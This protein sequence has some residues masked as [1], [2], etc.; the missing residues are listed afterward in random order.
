MK[1]A[2]KTLGLQPSVIARAMTRPHG[3]EA[4]RLLAAHFESRRGQPRS[5]RPCPAPTEAQTVAWIAS[6][7][8]GERVTAR[9]I[10]EHEGQ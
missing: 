7:L 1:T 10:E 6:T 4:L 3:P 8:L 9:Q 5:G 2:T